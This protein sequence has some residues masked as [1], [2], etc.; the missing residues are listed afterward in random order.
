MTPSFDPPSPLTTAVLFVVFNRPN[1]TSQVFEAI[2][3]AK[4]PRLYV[5]ADGPRMGRES[6]ADSVSLVRQIV[7]SVDWPCELKT[8]FQET[9]LGCKLAVSRAITW[10]FD[11]E[12]QGIIL[13]DDCLPSQ[14]FFW[15]CEELLYRYKYEKRISL[16]SGYNKQD[17]WCSNQCDYFFSSFGGIWGWATWRSSWEM[18]DLEM[19]DLE[20]FAT[21]NNFEKMLGNRL[22]KQRKKQL[23]KAKELILTGKMSSW[24]FPWAFT[25]HKVGG[26]AC[27]P[28]L[29]LIRNIGFGNESTHTKRA[30]DDAVSV[31][32]L[33]FP[34]KPN[35]NISPN[36]EYDILFLGSESLKT[37][38][39]NLVLKSINMVR[40]F[41]FVLCK[42]WLE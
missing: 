8:K 35:L 20:S 33:L 19:K 36:I 18:F 28:S 39:Y 42:Y 16:I 7:T 23:L 9:N 29:S 26:L 22:G 38:I 13:E 24:A 10:F 1:Q 12:E 14:S 25:R 17:H 31:H 5:A 34:L 37:R 27:V 32:E 6:E 40:R 2:R 41:W 21:D 15:Y 11:H 3:K 30:Q 4:P